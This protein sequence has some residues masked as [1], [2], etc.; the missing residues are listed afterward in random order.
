M[1]RNII[2]VPTMKFIEVGHPL[3][4]QRSV[5]FESHRTVLSGLPIDS[6]GFTVGGSHAAGY[7]T[8]MRG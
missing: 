4:A 6:G 3:T 7:W 1:K 2:V 8:A 5:T